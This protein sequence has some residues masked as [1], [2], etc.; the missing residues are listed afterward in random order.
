MRSLWLVLVFSLTTPLF[1]AQGEKDPTLFPVL[2]YDRIGTHYINKK[3]EVVLTVP[4]IAGRFVEGLARIHDRGMVGYIDQT[5]QVVIKPQNRPSLDFSQGLAIFYSSLNCQRADYKS[6]YGF[7]DREGKVV[8]QPTLT[9]P[10]NYFGNKFDFKEG[11]L[12]LVEVGQ[13]SGFIDKTG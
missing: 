4:Y 11:G 8:I 10:C 12:A 13:R 9:H 3:G 1:L 2:S 6:I 5:G 7:I